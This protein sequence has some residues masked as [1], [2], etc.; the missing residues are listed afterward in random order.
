M[1]EKTNDITELKVA[2]K[3]EKEF[4]LRFCPYILSHS[5]QQGAENV[6]TWS[7]IEHENS[8]LRF[9]VCLSVGAVPLV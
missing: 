6:G 5:T 3:E 2:R 1:R 8:R 4:A 9:L 7:Y